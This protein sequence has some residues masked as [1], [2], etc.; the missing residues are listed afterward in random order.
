MVF[1]CWG[2]CAI[3]CS[4]DMIMACGDKVYV[5]TLDYPSVRRWEVSDALL[6]YRVICDLAD[7]A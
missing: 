3:A 4:C 6:E 2:A 1:S 5:A 7:A